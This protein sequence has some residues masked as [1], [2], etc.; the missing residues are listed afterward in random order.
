MHRPTWPLCITT[1]ALW[2]LGLVRVSIIILVY[3]F[4]VRWLSWNK[5]HSAIMATIKKRK[6]RDKPAPYQ[7]QPKKP[8]VG[9]TLAATSA[10]PTTRIAVRQNLTLG[11]WLTVFAYVDAHCNA[12]MS[13]GNR[14]SG[15]KGP[16]SSLE[17]PTPY[18]HLSCWSKSVFFALD[19]MSFFMGHKLR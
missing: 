3:I 16:V 12:T 13:C 1:L 7:R 6:P 15:S 17:M 2:L 10:Q 5:P 8:K 9:D 14:V 11:D 18:F 19:V 4:G